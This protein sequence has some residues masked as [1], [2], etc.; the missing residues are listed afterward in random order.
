M[1]LSKNPSD[2]REASFIKEANMRF[3]GFYI[4]ESVFYGFAAKYA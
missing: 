4:Q 3:P 1:K 2:A